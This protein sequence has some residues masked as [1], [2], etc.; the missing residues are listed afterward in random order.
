MRILRKQLCKSRFFQNC[1]TFCFDLNWKHHNFDRREIR[2]MDF[3]KWTNFSMSKW[4]FSKIMPSFHLKRYW[5]FLGTHSTL[6][7]LYP[8]TRNSISRIAIVG[9]DNPLLVLTTTR[10]LAFFCQENQHFV[11]GL[12]NTF[13]KFNNTR[14]EGMCYSIEI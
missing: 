7:I 6:L 3:L 10:C 8:R 5:R 9:M 1:G 2:A 12:L 4:S 14:L 13:R 11:T